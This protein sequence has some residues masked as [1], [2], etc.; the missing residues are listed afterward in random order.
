MTLTETLKHLFERKG[1]NQ[2]TALSE[3]QKVL[4]DGLFGQSQMRWADRAV[5]PF[6]YSSVM[7]PD[8]TPAGAEWRR[9]RFRLK[10]DGTVLDNWTEYGRTKSGNPRW[11]KP[12]FLREAVT[13]L[14]PLTPKDVSPGNLE[15]K[16]S[17]ES[18][19]VSFARAQKGPIPNKQ[20]IISAAER[21]RNKGKTRQ[22]YN[23][24]PE[25]QAAIC[26]EAGVKPNTRGWGL[27]TI[28]NALKDWSGST[29][30]ITE[31]TESTES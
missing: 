9:V 12:L 24:W 26:S 13:N 21:L 3:L 19:V 17:S 2:S 27:D 1:C 31:R 11:R 16:A 5:A 23:T 10:G 22:S 8:D 7:R 30:E 4:S 15:I 6:G 25:Y 18:K 28:Q 14:W 29:G 20:N